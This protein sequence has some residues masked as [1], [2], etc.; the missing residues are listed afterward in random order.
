[1]ATSHA[2]VVRVVRVIT[3]LNVGGPARHVALLEAHLPARGYRSSLVHGALHTGEAEFPVQAGPGHDVVRIPSLGRAVRIGGDV[4]AWW[5][6]LRVMFRVKPDVVHTHT[7]KA[8]ALGR[9]AAFV[10]NRTRA[11]SGRAV[12]V[13][14][15]HGHV[16]HGYFGPWTSRLVQ[17]FERGLARLT[18]R[19]VAI[20]EGQRR[21]LVERYRIVPA[22][23]AVVVPLG[24]D[25]DPFAAADTSSR[26]SVRQAL[27]FA[28]DDVVCAFVGRL[29]PIKHVD[30]LVHA[31]A[32]VFARHPNGRLLIVGD[33]EC[34]AGLE[35]LVRDRGLDARVRFV[36]WRTDLTNIYAAADVVALSSRNEGTPV[37]LIEAMAA[38]RAVVATAVGGVPE[39]VEDGVTG[40]LV[41]DDDEVALAS[42]ID[43]LFAD[44]AARARLGA[45]ARDSVL[46]RFGYARLV[47]EIDAIYRDA[48]ADVRGAAGRL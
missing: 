25:L 31:C 41:A 42:A 9:I 29:V 26:A 39:V 38:G 48:L 20:T 6:V 36:G 15:F 47:T 33:G 13:H 5:R 10:Y 16:F 22:A 45:A 2:S 27:G 34:R 28:P 37:A 40:R 14:T 11:A 35:A 44:A 7:A 3:R 4:V 23:R 32:R 46:R 1:M 17:T 19:V 12:V 24:L 30:L 43:E 21:D 8:G 18:D